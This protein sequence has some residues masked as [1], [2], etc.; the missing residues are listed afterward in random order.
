MIHGFTSTP[1]L[2]RPLADHISDTFGW[3]VHAPLLPG[4]GLTPKALDD[5][6][7][8]EW[9][10]FTEQQLMKLCEKYS[11]VHL[12]GHSMGGTIAAQLADKFPRAVSTLTLLAPAMYFQNYLARFFFPLIRKL[13]ESLLTKWIIHKKNFDINQN[14]SYDRYSVKSVEQYYQ[15]CKSTRPGLDLQIPTRVFMPTHDETI[16]PRSA[17]WFFN[18]ISHANRKLIE[19]QKSQHLIFLGNENEKI[20][21]EIDDFLKLI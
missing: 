7:Y 5:V 18:R 12:M 2:V 10:E 13:P 6:K 17:K 21:S 14:L 16:Q 20:F 15:I 1:D 19:L 4:H 11:K 3:E 8:Q 9:Q